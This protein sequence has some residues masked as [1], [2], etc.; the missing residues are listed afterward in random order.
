MAIVKKNGLLI[1]IPKQFCLE[2]I[3]KLWPQNWKYKSPLLFYQTQPL[4]ITNME[5]FLQK[6]LKEIEEYIPKMELLNEAISQKNI[7][8]HLDHSLRV[9]IGVNKVL[10]KSD[11]SEYKRNFN[12]SRSL[13]FIANKFPRGRGKSP[14]QV[15]PEDVIG[16]KEVEVRLLKAKELL[17]ELDSLSPKANFNHYAFGL[18]NL[19]QT[20]KFLR[21][22]TQHHLSIIH[23][24]EK[25][26]A[27]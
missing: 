1:F 5:N 2:L 13:I 16:Q 11:P 19:R 3:D 6:E 17:K 25:A 18:L 20:K 9:I 15:L 23:D 7:G 8:W 26:A 24:I 21:I 12:L 4:Q 10:N 22:H 27:R 14:K